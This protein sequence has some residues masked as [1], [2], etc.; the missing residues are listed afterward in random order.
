M[1]CIMIRA[2]IPSYSHSHLL[3]KII[4]K[5]FTCDINRRK[6]KRLRSH[7]V[8]SVPFT[9]CAFIRPRY[10]FSTAT[11]WT[12]TVHTRAVFN[13]SICYRSGFLSSTSTCRHAVR[14]NS[15][16]NKKDNLLVVGDSWECYIYSIPMLYG[17]NQPFAI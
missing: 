13:V 4:F 3:A 11:A 6:P 12:F 1:R 10:F 5:V 9:V 14:H 2:L 17:A 16:T 7:T 15:S 8:G